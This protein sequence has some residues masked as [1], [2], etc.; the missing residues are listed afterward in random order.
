MPLAKLSA[1]AAG[2]GLADLAEDH[3]GEGRGQRDDPQDG[4]D[5]H[6]PGEERHPGQAHA[7]G[8]VRH[9]R[10]GHAHGTERRGRP[11]SPPWPR[12]PA[13]RRRCRRR[14]TP[15]ST[16]TLVTKIP[17]ETSQ[18][19]SDSG[20][21]PGE[22]DGGRA[23]LERARRTIARPRNR[24]TTPTSTRATSEL[25]RQHGGARHP[26][27]R[28]RW[29]R[30]R[31]PRPGPPGPAWSGCSEKPMKSRPME[32][33]SPVPISRSSGPGAGRSD[34]APRRRGRAGRSRVWSR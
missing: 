12:C 16:A 3:V 13:G 30:R 34:R 8:A 9:H 1:R 32:M 27:S 4:G 11:S 19:H 6:R 21:G 2:V 22:R 7:H 25:V 5:Q 20:G 29:P 23:D 10:G 31:R 15:P 33:W 24:G 14:R 28:C 18:P 17:A 26:G